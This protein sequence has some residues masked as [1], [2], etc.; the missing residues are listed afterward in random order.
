MCK[1]TSNDLVIFCRSFGQA[2]LLWRQ[3]RDVFPVLRVIE[4]RCC[5]V[6]CTA[7]GVATLPRI[8]QGHTSW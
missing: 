3:L 1:P 2:D 5:V 8:L 6:D 4:V 7:I